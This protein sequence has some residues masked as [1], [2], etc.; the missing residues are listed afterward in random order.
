[1][2]RDCHRDINAQN[3]EKTK[4][5]NISGDIGTIKNLP[6]GCVECHPKE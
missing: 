5:T 3:R 4:A 2:C 6:V 1:M